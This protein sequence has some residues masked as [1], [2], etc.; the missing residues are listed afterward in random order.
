MVTYLSLTGC[1][2]CHDT[3]MSQGSIVAQGPRV[4]MMPLVYDLAD[5]V[6]RGQVSC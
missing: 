2:V 3:S 5:G 1:L 4:E 6:S